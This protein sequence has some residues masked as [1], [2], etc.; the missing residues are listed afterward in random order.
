MPA[1]TTVLK[2]LCHGSYCELI[3]SIAEHRAGCRLPPTLAAPPAVSTKP[4]ARR[5][6]LKK[7]IQMFFQEIHPNPR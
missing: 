5:R 3:L 6:L 2:L 4:V 1:H 7:S